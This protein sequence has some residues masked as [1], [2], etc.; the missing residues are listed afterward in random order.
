MTITESKRLGVQELAELDDRS[1]YWH[2][3][4]LESEALYIIREVVAEFDRPGL[5]F[6][7][8]KDSAV[9]LHLAVKALRPAH[10]PFPCGPHRHRPQLSRGHRFPRSRRPNGLAW[11]WSWARLTRQ[12]PQG[13]FQ[14]HRVLI[15]LVTACRHQ[16]CWKP[17][18]RGNSPR[19]SAV[20]GAMRSDHAQRSVCTPCATNS[21]SGI[22]AISGPE[23]WSLYNGIHWIRPAHARLPALQLDGAGHLALH[24][25]GE[26]RPAG[27]LLRS[28]ARGI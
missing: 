8:G 4:A 24:S 3:R 28:P 6:S 17:F 15:S 25:R 1:E 18:A 27:N 19:F 22:H 13:V 20:R 11:T 23:V 5:L 10:L 9:L 7:G 26:H 14:P 2:L 21:A 12:L 16:C